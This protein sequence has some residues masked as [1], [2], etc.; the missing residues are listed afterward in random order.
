MNTPSNNFIGPRRHARA[1][2]LVELLV[3]I[4]IIGI[5]AAM[6]LA[7]LAAAKDRAYRTVCITNLKQFGTT[8]CMYNN[9]NR[10]TFVQP[11]WDGGTPGNV[12]GGGVYAGYLYG[13]NVATLVPNASSGTAPWATG[14]WWKYMGNSKSYFC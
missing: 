12:P 7:V 14:L 2:T 6:L 13:T 11:N 4:A 3:V 8:D 1:F 10:D 9:D 5:L